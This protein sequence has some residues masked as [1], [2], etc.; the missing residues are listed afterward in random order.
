MKS[1]KLDANG[2]LAMENG[3]FIWIDGEDAIAQQLRIS[4]QTIKGEWFLDPED[5][6]DMGPIFSKVF[7]ENEAK[8][9]VIEAALQVPDIVSVEDIAFTRNTVTRKME[10]DL[11][12]TK[13][14]GTAIQLEGV[15]IGGMGT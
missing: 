9:S 12:V 7:D 15:N 13:Q 1:L 14:D 4:I 8:N 2:D 5:G 10:I 6:M 11:S 3:S